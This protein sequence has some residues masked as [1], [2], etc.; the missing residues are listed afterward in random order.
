MKI[1]RLWWIIRLSLTRGG[2]K[3]A[4]YAKR[5]GIYG[6]IGNNVTIQSRTIPIYSELIKFHNN[7]AIARNVD[8]CT[9]DIIHTVLNRMHGEFKYRERI[10]CIEIMDNVFVGSNSVILYGT[11]IGPN[12]IVAS[13]SVV[14]KDCEPDSVYAGCPARKVGSFSDFTKKRKL[15]EESGT[16]SVTTHNQALTAEEKEKAWDAFYKAHDSE[17]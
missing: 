16:I 17:S 15:G 12:V 11:K 3:R 1:K 4:E 6:E 5:K 7:I 8:F 10:G 2:R 13:G 14:V 9:H